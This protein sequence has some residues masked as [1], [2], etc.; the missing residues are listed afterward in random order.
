[1]LGHQPDLGARCGMAAP[2][3]TL[4]DCLDSLNPQGPDALFPTAPVPGDPVPRTNAQLFY[5]VVARPNSL[6]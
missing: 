4:K 3:L 6:P 2:L 5:C 1:M